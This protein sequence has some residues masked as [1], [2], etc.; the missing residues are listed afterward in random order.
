[1]KTDSYAFGAFVGQGADIYVFLVATS[2]HELPG[3]LTELI[4]GVGKVHFQ[5]TTATKHSLIVILDSEK[6]EP[7]LFAIPVTADALEA[8]GAVVEGMGQNSDFGFG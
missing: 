3:Q 4:N 1:V 8:S 6:A 5:D 2:F 7:F